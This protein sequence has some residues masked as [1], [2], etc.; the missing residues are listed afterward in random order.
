MLFLALNLLL[1]TSIVYLHKCLNA[2][3]LLSTNL[4]HL[5]NFYCTTS[6]HS[7]SC[8]TPSKFFPSAKGIKLWEVQSTPELSRDLKI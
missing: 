1:F 3:T 5:D 4:I 2:C 8:L 7:T 6:S